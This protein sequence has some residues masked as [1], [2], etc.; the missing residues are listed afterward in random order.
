MDREGIDAGRKAWSPTDEHR[1]LV[2]LRRGRAREARRGSM[3]VL[4]VGCALP[5]DRFTH[6]D[7]G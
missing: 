3:V 7:G 1:D 4:D 6:P 5:G 2:E